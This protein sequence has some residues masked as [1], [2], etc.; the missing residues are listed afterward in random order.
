ML[1]RNEGPADRTIRVVGGSLLTVVGLFLLGGLEAS[2]V[3]IVAA[4]FGVWFI[5]TGAFGFCP[6]YVPFG[7]TTLPK[8][9]D[10]PSSQR[11]GQAT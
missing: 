10:A 11:A 6:L 5:V 9:Q 1:Q 8:R 3:G 2:A 7:F 4:A